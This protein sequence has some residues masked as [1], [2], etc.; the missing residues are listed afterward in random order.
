MTCLVINNVDIL[1]TGSLEG[2][3]LVIKDKEIAARGLTTVRIQLV[4]GLEDGLGVSGAVVAE[5]VH[6]GLARLDPAAGGAAAESLLEEAVPVLDGAEEVADVDEVEGVVLPGP[7]Q[8]GIVDL[9]S[10][11]GRDPFGLAGREVGADNIGGGELVGKVT[12]RCVS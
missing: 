12:R 10:D 7:R 6:V 8:R 9:E 2:A 5:E 11:V 3:T 1:E 4:P